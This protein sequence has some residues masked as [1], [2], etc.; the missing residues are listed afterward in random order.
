MNIKISPWINTRTYYI[1]KNLISFIQ[2]LKNNIEY[3]LKDNNAILW[4]NILKNKN[5]KDIPISFLAQLQKKQ[6][7]ISSEKFLTPNKI[8][9]D[10]AI[11]YE[12]KNISHYSSRKRELLINNNYLLGI[13]LELNYK[14]NLK[15]RHC[16]N[17]KD[18]N[19][20]SIN[21]EQAEKIINDFYELGIYHVILTG[22]EC[23]IN[24]VFLKIAKYIR[25]KNLALTIQTNGQA[26]FDNKKLIDEIV[27]LYPYKIK[28]SVYSMNSKIH[29][30]ITGVKGS[31]NKT[32]SVIDNLK[33]HNI[34]IA[35]N[36][37]L[38]SYNANSYI[39]I[40]KFAQENNIEFSC[41]CKFINN[42]KN[43]NLNA[44]LSITDMEKFY[45]DTIE[46]YERRDEFTSCNYQICAAGF[47]K[48]S[49]RPNLDI[50]PCTGF[51]YV[52]ANYN[53]TPFKIFKNNILPE[54]K[55][56]FIRL[57]LK[58]CFKYEYCKYCLYCASIVSYEKYYLKKS[59]FL[60]E[61]AKAYYNAYLKHKQLQK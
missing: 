32:L 11:S 58:E 43:N 27:K 5:I 54:F 60:C 26:F 21:F 42:P 39:D 44:K 2:D 24:P 28:F 25:S 13:S 7:I 1:N 50:T 47:D 49:I 51:N 41:G 9:W 35:I 10:F 55:K 16:H 36:T 4:N 18:M 12:A 37:V 19:Q 8:F 56:N 53:K 14:C 33:K 3:V 45:A 17:P 34:D 22:G 31:L 59:L 48:L 38:L 46:R 20:Y 52:L 40:E 61:D 29:D 23:T 6:L 30:N 15:C 57:N